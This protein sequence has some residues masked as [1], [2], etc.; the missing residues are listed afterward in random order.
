MTSC[1]FAFVF[2]LCLTNL[3]SKEALLMALQDMS[4]KLH[5]VILQPCTV[6]KY[7]RSVVHDHV[8]KDLNSII[9]S[10]DFNGVFEN[11]RLLKTEEAEA[12]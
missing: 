11:E 4:P 5:V 7:F 10:I 9:N 3:P 6:N 2:F 12:S 1:P 8:K